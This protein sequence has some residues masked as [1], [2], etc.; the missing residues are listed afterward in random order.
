MDSRAE[1]LAAAFE[2]TN[3]AVVATVEGCTAEEWRA[4]CVNEGRPVGVVA[5]HIAAGYLLTRDVVAAV[6]SGQPLPPHVGARPEEGDA[7]NARQAAEHAGV[8]QAEVLALADRNAAEV[9]AFIRGLTSEQLGRRAVFAPHPTSA[10]I[11]QH[12]VVGHAAG[13]LA[14]IQATLAALRSEI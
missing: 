2:D 3:C 14:N 5:Y 9:A 6:A 4:A 1:Q 8:T 10:D 11:V 12:L 13:H 7:M